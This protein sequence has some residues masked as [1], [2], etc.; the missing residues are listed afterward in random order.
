MPT[1]T[2]ATAQRCPAIQ[3]LQAISGK[4]K[5]VILYRFTQQ[6][7]WHFGALN[8][9]ISPCPTR[10]LA[11]QLAALCADGFIQKT[12]L[13]NQPLATVYR[14]TDRGEALVP[15]IQAI[16]ATGESEVNI[17]R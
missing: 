13:S 5:A 6:P 11:R 7:E 4:W 17:Q 3:L 2:S 9:S 10:M 1:C 8:A 16:A 15:V 12:V 14:L